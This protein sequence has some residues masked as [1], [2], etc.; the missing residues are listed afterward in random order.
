MWVCG[1]VCMFSMDGQTAQGIWTK[2][3]GDLPDLGEMVLSHPPGSSGPG[4][5][6]EIHL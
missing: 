4:V 2:F 5:D 6:P 3:G 1:C